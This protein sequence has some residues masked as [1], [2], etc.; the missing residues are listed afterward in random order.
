MVFA[1]GL[2]AVK[3]FKTVF[4]MKFKSLTP[5]RVR[6]VNTPTGGGA[7]QWILCNFL[8]VLRKIKRNFFDFSPLY[9][10][11]TLKFATCH[12]KQPGETCPTCVFARDGG[13]SCSP[14]QCLNSTQ[15]RSI[16]AFLSNKCFNNINI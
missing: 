8:D 6:C 11:L 1:R 16:A 4:L 14:G 13:N 7:L 2:Q 15:Q 10:L 12:I 3:S 5:F 9:L